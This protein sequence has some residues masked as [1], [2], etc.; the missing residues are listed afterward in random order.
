MWPLPRVLD[1]PMKASDED[2]AFFMQCLVDIL[3][4]KGYIENVKY[5]VTEA[6]W[7]KF[8]QLVAERCMPTMKDLAVMSE[9]VIPDN[10]TMQFA[11][12]KLLS[13]EIDALYGIQR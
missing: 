10:K 4:Q 1:G 2:K 7:K 11:L 3:C 6:G 13:M 5:D 8:E 9:V 12:A